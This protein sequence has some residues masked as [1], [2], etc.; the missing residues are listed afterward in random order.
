LR[1]YLGAFRIKSGF[2]TRR[3]KERPDF[4]DLDYFKTHDQQP[5][6]HLR[7]ERTPTDKAP[8]SCTL[9]HFE[10]PGIV[11]GIEPKPGMISGQVWAVSVKEEAH[12]YP[13]GTAIRIGRIEPGLYA[14]VL[15]KIAHGYAVAEVGIDGFHHALPS[16]ILGKSDDFCHLVGS[17]PDIPPENTAG[18]I[19]D[20][21]WSIIFIGKGPF[22]KK[23]YLA[24][25]VRLFPFFKSPE[26]QII[27]GEL[28]DNGLSRF[29][30]EAS[31]MPNPR[32]SRGV[33]IV[34]PK[35]APPEPVAPSRLDKSDQE[36]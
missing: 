28:T 19:F 12:S 35:L 13:D 24:I 9:W 31:S 7:T 32:P 4:I 22:S 15:A 21:A 17:K 2:P 18:P 26:Y 6:A 23:P 27:A 25:E 34:Q 33:Q 11:Q 16:L 5:I 3:P 36:N 20:L 29:L 14:R 30:D 10:L 1:N 8:L